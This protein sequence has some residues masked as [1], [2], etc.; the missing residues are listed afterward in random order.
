[1]NNLVWLKKGRPNG[2]PAF[3][4][5]YRLLVAFNVSLTGVPSVVTAGLLV[6]V[7]K[8]NATLEPAGDTLK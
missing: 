4:L 8:C 3:S 6:P 7:L 5:T 1:M 2:A